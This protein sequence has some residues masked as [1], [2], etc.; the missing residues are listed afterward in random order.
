MKQLELDVVAFI[1][2]TDWIDAAEHPPEYSGWYEVRYK[3][4]E[5]EREL[6]GGLDVERRWWH[7]G[8]QTFSWPV[9]VGRDTEEDEKIAVDKQATAP[10][11][12]LEYRG[13]KQPMLR[14][15]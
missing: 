4:S 11:S 12:M 7:G 3:M 1:G 2:V 9:V 13:L 8:D 15:R 5:E 14:R 10:L 6:R